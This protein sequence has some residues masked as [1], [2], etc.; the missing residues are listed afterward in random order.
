MKKVK[1]GEVCEILN[2]FAFKSLLYVNEGI[3]IIRITNVQK[4]YIEDSDPKYYPIEYTNS[5][6][7]Y[8]LKENDLL[9]SLTGNVG[10]VG[11]ISKTMLPAALNQ[12]VACLR[13]IDSLISKEYVFQ[14]LNSDLFEQ[15]A[16]RSSNGVAQK[17][18]STDWLKKV[19]ITYPSVEQQELITSTL[20]L[21]ERL[22]CCRKE[23]NKKLNELVKSRFNE[24]FGDPV[25]NEMGWEKHR[26]SKLTLKIGSGATPRGGRESYVN[27]GI[28][29]IRS[30]N[31]YD[32]KFMF[33]DLAYLTNIQAEKLNNVI[34]E[35]DD[36]LLNITGASVSRCCIVPQNILPA[37]VNQHV[38]IIRCK[39]HLLSPIFLNQ[40]LI[41]SE[42]KS[43]LLKIGESSGATRQAITKNQIE[44]LY[45]PLP[46]LS[47]Q[48][49]FADFV[50]QVDKSQLAIQKSL[51]ELETLK[52]S[53][54]Q[55]YF[56]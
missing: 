8:I 20:N 37:R 42:F 14:F 38:S 9:M 31:V 13:T 51:E 25:L 12:R 49:E 26:L 29:L 11:L 10:R 16:I 39:K 7:K 17:N 28:A 3:R 23:Q 2:G 52:K 15:S 21:I 36:V 30:M 46:P 41:T 32:G 34:V 53:L 43:L 4:G 54:M 27:E 40:L 35:S 56:G 47:L 18:L 44:E 1:L 45:V 19:E 22:I 48:N 24:M 55:E 5:I 6:E 33:K 50:A